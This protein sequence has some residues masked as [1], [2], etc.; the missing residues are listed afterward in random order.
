MHVWWLVAKQPFT[1]VMVS[2]ANNYS[3]WFPT[4]RGILHGSP[5]DSSS[6]F[7]RFSNRLRSGPTHP[8]FNWILAQSISL[9]FDLHKL[10]AGDEFLALSRS[11]DRHI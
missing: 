3:V 1:L 9:P 2:S 5:W 4:V 7:W 6:G 10:I 8:K 11:Q